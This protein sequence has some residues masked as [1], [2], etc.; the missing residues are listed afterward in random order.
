LEGL[1]L[2]RNK[3]DKN[4]KT[5]TEPWEQSIY[6]TEESTGMTRVQ[7]RKQKKGNSI[8]LTVLVILL[9]IIIA[10]PTAAFIYLHGDHSPAISASSTQS[11]SKTLAKTTQTSSTDTKSSS[12][13]STKD[14]T[15][16]TS[17]KKKA[18]STSSSKAESSS[19]SDDSQG[20]QTTT[21]MD[22]EGLNQIAARTGVD[23]QTIAD[24]NGI[25]IAADGSFSP[26]IQPGQTLR[27]R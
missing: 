19:S 22:G 10:A 21:V 14:E 11:S 9:I 3:K 4:K 12:T 20:E 18:S 15:S 1:I 27:I 25:T 16:T 17:S 7:Q 23:A 2:A 8:F 13:K 24:L 6:D 5:T 26:A